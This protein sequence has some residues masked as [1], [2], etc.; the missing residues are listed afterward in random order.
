MKVLGINIFGHDH[1]VCIIDTKKKD[2]FAISLE[3]VNRIKH[4]NNILDFII[5]EYPDEFKNIEHICLGGGNQKNDFTINVGK[6]YVNILKQRARFYKRFKPSFKKDQV[7]LI[8]RNVIN[9]PFK[10]GPLNY[11]TY[12]CEKLSNRFINKNDFSKDDFSKYISKM[13]NINEKAICFYDHH[14][15]HAASAYYFSGFKDKVISVTMDGYGDDFYSKAYLCTNGNMELIGSSKVRLIDNATTEENLL[16]VGTLYG[17]FTEA[18]DLIR[19]S[20]EGKVEALAA[21]GNSNNEIYYDLM[22][23]YSI[24][25]NSIMFNDSIDKYYDLQYLYSIRNK[26]GK[27]DFCAAIQA[28][29][30]DLMIDYTKVLKEQYNVTKICLSGGVTANVI[31]NLSIFEKNTFEDIYVFPAMADD[32]VAVGA[33]VL[34]LHEEGEDISFLKDFEMPYWGPTINYKNDLEQ[35]LEENSK[36]IRYELNENWFHEIAVKLMNDEVGAVVLDKM[37]FGPRALGNRSIIASPL[38]NTTR[39]KINQNIKKR[40]SYQPFCPSVLAEER[41]RLFEKSLPNKHM[42]FAFRLKKEFQSK[43]P[44]AVHIDL[45]G[46][47]QFVEFKDNPKYYT[48]IKEFKK[49]SGFGVIIDTSFNLHGRTIVRTPQDAIDDFLDCNLDFL[50]IE[51]YIIHRN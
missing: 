33:A 30:N 10:F 51:N 20:E 4:D 9:N 28:F 50:I 37:E 32:G 18:M 5:A 2:I 25:D 16:S 34:K 27:E 35:I 40:P 46:R 11:I 1:S 8:N 36:K 23:S 43:L 41:E 38:N 17:N 39:N 49:L 48:L 19:N 44:S 45:T 14:K 15:S 7:A 3:R 26:Y 31:T 22:K 12:F 47:P 42:T 24:V 29:L 13:F 6:F 21:Y